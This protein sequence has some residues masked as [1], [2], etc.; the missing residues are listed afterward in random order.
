MVGSPCCSACHPPGGPGR[1]PAGLRRKASRRSGARSAPAALV[2]SPP[3]FPLGCAPA[4]VENWVGL[5]PRPGDKVSGAPGGPKAWPPARGPSRSPVSCRA[6]VSVLPAA[7]Q[8]EP[9]I[10]DCKYSEAERHVSLAHEP[11]ARGGGHARLPG[12]RERD[13]KPTARVWPRAGSAPCP[14]APASWR[15]GA[16]AVGV[17]QGRFCR[18]PV[19]PAGHTS[20]G[21]C[22]EEAAQLLGVRRDAE[23]AGAWVPRSAQTGGGYTESP[24]TL[25]LFF[26]PRLTMRC[27]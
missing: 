20:S 17:W 25:S 18:G 4:A 21:T 12:G 14:A 8:R 11:A 27:H 26:N 6:P 5:T 23:G 2:L 22:R 1:D 16:G 19:F 24:N 10:G 3:S 9:F 13:P 15:P 7:C